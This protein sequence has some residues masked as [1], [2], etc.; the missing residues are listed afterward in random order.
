M[1]H[2]RPLQRGGK[3]TG[4]GVHPRPH[5]VRQPGAEGAEGD[6]KHNKHG[7]QEQGNGKYPVGDYLIDL[8]AEGQLP[9]GAPLDHRGG[10]HLLDILVAAVGN[11]RLPVAQ[12]AGVLI[13]RHQGVQLLLHIRRQA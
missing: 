11:Q 1:G 13:L 9:G 7:A 6:D 3:P 8:F 5:P 2:A 10:D 4:Q 12:A